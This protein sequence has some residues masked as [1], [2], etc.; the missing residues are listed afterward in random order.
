MAD[1]KISGLAAKASPAD[2]DV[3]AIVDTTVSPIETKKITY[4]NL[5]TAIGASYLPLSGGALTGDI[6]VSDASPQVTIDGRDLSV[7]GAKLDGIESGATADQTAAEIEGVLTANLITGQA[8]DSPAAAAAGDLLLIA[9]VSAS[10]QSLKQVTAQSIADLASAGGAFEADADGLISASSEPVLDAASGD[11]VAYT[12]NYTTNKAAGNDTG[13]LINQT[14]TASP[15]TSLLADFQV[16]GTSKFKV[17]NSGN[18]QIP[19]NATIYGD[20]SD[21]IQI[22]EAGMNVVRNN[23]PFIVANLPNK[24]GLILASNVSLQWD[25]GTASNVNGSSDLFLHRDAANTLALRN[26]TNAQTFNVYN[27]YTDASNYER[28]FVKWDT[29]V[30]KIGNEEAGTGTARDVWLVSGTNVYGIGG[31]AGNPSLKIQ[32]STTGYPQMSFLQGTTSRCRIQYSHALGE[33][34]VDQASNFNFAI[35]LEASSTVVF[36]NLPTSDPTNAGQLWN[37]SGTL[38][39]SAG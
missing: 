4:A 25:N 38:K 33:M 14:D 6:T 20:S 7:D 15:G 39:V 17:F 21:G 8:A 36:S 13:L 11:E 2:D 22:T 34:Y 26:S 10:P 32:G 9:D 27:T 29:N 1:T 18:L 37:D 16:G 31:Q 30:L 3:V 28:G 23:A 35:P 12:F 19:N 24:E 5:K